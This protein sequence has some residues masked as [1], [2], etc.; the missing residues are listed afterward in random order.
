M[1]KSIFLVLLILGISTTLYSQTYYR[2]FRG[3][4]NVGYTEYLANSTT[5]LGG[6]YPGILYVASGDVYS[7]GA[8]GRTYFINPTR[9][10]AEN[11]SALIDYGKESDNIFFVDGGVQMNRLMVSNY[12]TYWDNVQLYNTGT[13]AFLESAGDENG[14]H[15]VSKTAGKVFV[16]DK[17]GIG[18][19]VSSSNLVPGAALTVSG[20]TFIGDSNS[21]SS[22]NISQKSNSYLLWVQK[23]IV[24]E[25]FAIVN[26]KD[27][28]DHVFHSDY[29]LSSLQEVENFIEEN[30]H[31]PGVP[32]E[33]D[34]I[35]NGYNLHEMN[36]I[37]LQK[38][39][40]LTLYVIKQ[41]KEIEALKSKRE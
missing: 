29:K 24:S 21:A 28:S 18:M 36:K 23:G 15:I 39:E 37:L 7:V 20:A 12:N 32:S 5:F 26:A 31:L 2:M 17:V 3:S 33:K 38:I 27:W 4:G 34:V 30:K 9:K 35:E 10:S 16:H 25:N 22:F 13:D 8:G 19:P 40:E 14:L 1:K 11:I 6:D 41:N